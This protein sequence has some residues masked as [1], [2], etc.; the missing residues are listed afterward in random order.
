M[1]EL[2]AAFGL[3]VKLL[4]IQALNFAIL[5]VV[6]WKFLYTPVLKMI[7]ERREK[8]AEGVRKAEAADRKLAD[9]DTEGK[10]IVA[11][12]GKE[13]EGLV[14]SGRSKAA[15]EGA[16]ILKRSQEKADELLADAN[17]RAEEAKRLALAAGQKEIARAAMLAAEKILKEKHS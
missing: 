13:A 16:E 1:S 2:F 12:A 5:L 11:G 3:D 8:V 9:A 17:A 15:Q 6:L 10:S 14:A 4:L 7:D